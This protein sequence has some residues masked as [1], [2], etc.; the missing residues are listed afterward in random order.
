MKVSAI[1]SARASK[2]GPTLHPTKPA[3]KGVDLRIS[4]KPRVDEASSGKIIFEMNDLEY[5][6]C[7]VDIYAAMRSSSHTPSTQHQSRPPSEDHK[8]Y[9]YNN[10]LV[11]VLVHYLV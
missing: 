10:Y 6:G 2:V 11:H 3:H 1:I 8:L 5:P 7:V 4:S 9:M